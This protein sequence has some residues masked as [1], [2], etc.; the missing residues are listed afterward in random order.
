MSNYDT[1]TREV[2]RV[3][4]TGDPEQ[5]EQAQDMLSCITFTDEATADLLTELEYK[6]RDAL[7]TP[8][9]DEILFR[10]LELQASLKG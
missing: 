10:A 9:E 1:L 5:I 3:V 4:A 8:S 6:L 7:I 2:D